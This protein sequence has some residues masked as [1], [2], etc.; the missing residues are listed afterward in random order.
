VGKGKGKVSLQ[1]GVNW[2]CGEA[3]FQQANSRRLPA[4][5]HGVDSLPY[6]VADE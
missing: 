1:P 2:F 5:S 3:C 4:A 6:I